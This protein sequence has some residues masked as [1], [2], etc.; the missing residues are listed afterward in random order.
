MK[1]LII[2]LIITTL[3][4]CS[5]AHA[6]FLSKPTVAKKLAGVSLG[7]SKDEIYYAL[8]EP[9]HVL[10]PAEKKENCNDEQSNFKFCRS[11]QIAYIHDLVKEGKHPKGFDDWA[12]ERNGFRLDIEFSDNKIISLGCYSQSDKMNKL[13]QA[14]EILLGDSEN[15]IIK[16]LGEPTQSRIEN[17]YKEITYSKLNTKYFLTKRQVYMIKIGGRASN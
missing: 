1:K 13:C 7:E 5:I 4:F 3:L 14:N 15:T 2:K 6:D 8:G 9:S 10:L 12:Y 16:K 11:R 17:L